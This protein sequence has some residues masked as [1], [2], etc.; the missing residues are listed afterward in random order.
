[1]VVLSPEQKELWFDFK[2][3]KNGRYALVI[4]YFTPA[5]DKETEIAVESSSE[6]GKNLY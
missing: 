5:G 3:A 2:Q 4:D 1:L 6:K